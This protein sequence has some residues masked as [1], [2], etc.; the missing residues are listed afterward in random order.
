MIR[1]DISPSAPVPS[2]V[3][4]EADA[5]AGST[6]QPVT[7]TA[8]PNAASVRTTPSR[9]SHAV[10]I[11]PFPA[12][13]FYIQC[14]PAM[15]VVPGRSTTVECSISLANGYNS[16]ISLA[17]RV[18]GMDCSLNPDRIKALPDLTSM[19]TKLTVS[20][21]ASAPVGTRAASVMATGGETGSALRQADL[22]VNVPP[23]FSVSCESVGTSFVLGTKATV[24]CWVS[25]LDGFDDPVS[26]TLTKTGGLQAGLDTTALPASPNQTRAFTIEVD[27]EGLQS[28]PYVVQVAAASN[29]YVQE[30]TAVFQVVP[31][32]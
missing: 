4:S 6:S 28:R 14:W 10:D 22:K 9:T 2:P 3:K 16:D 5:A 29:R 25:F 20:A 23:P 32:P 31:A 19:T 24:K 18:D 11:S 7:G 13:D 12:S 17:C 27:T 1:G 15:T 21:P 26:L 30:A 8:T